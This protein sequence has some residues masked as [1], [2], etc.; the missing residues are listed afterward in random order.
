MLERPLSSA[1]LCVALSASTL[2]ATTASPAVAA[3]PSSTAPSGTTTLHQ[4]SEFV[5]LSKD[6]L[7][8]TDC[9]TEDDID[10]RTF[11][12]ALYGGYG[13]SYRLCGLSVDGWT[14]GGIGVES[15]V[16]VV[17]SLTDMT[18]TSPDGTV[19]HAVLMG[20]TTSKGVTTSHY[21]TCYV[22]PYY[23]STDT[24]TNPLTGGTWSIA[25][26]G[27]ISSASLTTRADMTDVVFQH[28]YC[29]ASEQNLL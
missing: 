15:D 23:L 28:N 6:P 8:P 5:Q 10:Y 19:H 1:L 20:T 14:A 17:G 16:Y 7:L 27:Q 4:T 22:P 9:L 3:K 2:L 29:P 26:S 25:L 12:G 21:A 13:T 11:A 24:G 18:I